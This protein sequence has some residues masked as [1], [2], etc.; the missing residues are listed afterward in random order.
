LDLEGAVWSADKKTIATLIEGRVHLWSGDTK[1]HLKKLEDDQ[2]AI[3]LAFSPD[4][5][6]LYLGYENN[7]PSVYDDVLSSTK[8][9]GFDLA[10]TINPETDRGAGSLVVTADGAWLLGRCN[11]VDVCIWSTKTGKA[12]HTTTPLTTDPEIKTITLEGPTRA[13]ITAETGK[14]YRVAIPSLRIVR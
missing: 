13:R 6:K 12:V 7:P 4:G 11:T 3:S 9:R 2:S 5:K 14:S 10:S 1:A 8:M